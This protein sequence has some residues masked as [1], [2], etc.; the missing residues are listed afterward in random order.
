MRVAN[1]AAM[2]L[3]A[4]ITLC[5]ISAAPASATNTTPCTQTGDLVTIIHEGGY[6]CFANPG[7]IAYEMYDVFYVW[8]GVN[9]V[10][11]AWEDE[12]GRY[13]TMELGAWTVLVHEAQD[14]GTRPLV[15]KRIYQ[16]WIL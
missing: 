8:T 2:A 11:I 4:A 6:T 13:N 7:T 1:K 16:I 9:A 15:F 10:Q 5:F 3:F 14:D 12:A